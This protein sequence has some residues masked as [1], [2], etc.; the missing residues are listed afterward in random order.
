MIGGGGRTLSCLFTCSDAG[1]RANRIDSYQTLL[2]D[3]WIGVR[4][5][6]VVKLRIRSFLSC[7]HIR[8][9]A[10]SS[11]LMLKMPLI[12]VSSVF[13]YNRMSWQYHPWDFFLLLFKKEKKKKL[14]LPHLCLHF[15]LHIK[16][17]PSG[18]A[19]HIY[20]WLVT[21]NE[22]VKNGRVFFFECARTT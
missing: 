21:L 8:S 17:I 18:P 6:A 4:N 13:L 10:T 9:N 12:A 16:E 11:G 20:I 7:P 2:F 5:L 22:H 1:E 14:H 19:L 3:I 15:N